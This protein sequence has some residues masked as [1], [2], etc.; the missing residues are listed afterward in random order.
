M[1]TCIKS[2]F[3]KIWEMWN[4]IEIV[5]GEH[6]FK[7]EPMRWLDT[8][9]CSGVSLPETAI[10]G[11]VIDRYTVEKGFPASAQKTCYTRITC[12]LV[13]GKIIDMYECQYYRAADGV[14]E[15]HN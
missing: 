11:V 9:S 5:T 4:K 1:V 14:L 10:E 12:R 6:F 8:C 3:Q 7:A 13:T 2:S 15:Y